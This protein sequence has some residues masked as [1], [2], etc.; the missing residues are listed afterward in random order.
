[1]GWATLAIAAS[2]AVAAASPG[3][4]GLAVVLFVG[5]ATVAP[6]L[7][8]LYGR[9]GAVAPEGASTEAFGWIAVGLLAGSSLGAALGGAVV[10]AW[11]SRV[12]FL[13]A[14]AVPAVVAVAVLVWVRRQEAAPLAGE[15]LPS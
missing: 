7:A 10:D 9:V 2:I 6:G 13:L 15:P 8:R 3:R 11:G 4:V 14:A 1:V 5:G 12:D